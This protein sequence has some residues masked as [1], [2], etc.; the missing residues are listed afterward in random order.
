[1]W[2]ITNISNQ[3]TQSQLVALFQKTTLTDNVIG[4]HM[5]ANNYFTNLLMKAFLN[6]LKSFNDK[7]LIQN[8]LQS[9]KNLLDCHSSLSN[10]DNSNEQ[11]SVF[12]QFQ[13]FEGNQTIDWL[14]EK[15]SISGQDVQPENDQEVLAIFN[16][17]NEI[18]SA[19]Q[20]LDMNNQNDLDPH[21]SNQNDNIE[22]VF[23]I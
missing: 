7:A 8:L 2:A 17:S 23:Q 19:S 13:K 20:A 10:I 12:E 6:G 15:Y 4:E 14:L 1:M 3:G 11:T 16:L 9:I 21:D 5:P 18:I 22:N